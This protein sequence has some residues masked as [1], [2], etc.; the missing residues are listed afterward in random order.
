MKGIMLNK[1][2]VS[3]VIVCGIAASGIP[4]RAAAAAS[5]TSWKVSGELE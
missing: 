3:I 2:I 4:G 1:S 5:K